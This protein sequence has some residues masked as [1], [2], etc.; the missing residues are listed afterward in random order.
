VAKTL[1][2][3]YEDRN[4]DVAPE[5]IFEMPTITE[6]GEEVLF[7]YDLIVTLLAIMAVVIASVGE[8]LKSCPTKGSK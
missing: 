8:C 5:S 6:I 4:I 2:S 1:R 7:R 3:L